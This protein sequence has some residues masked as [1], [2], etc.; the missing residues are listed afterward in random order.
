MVKIQ[1]LT[2]AGDQGP[3]VLHLFCTISI[4]LKKVLR[5]SEAQTPCCDNDAT[6]NSHNK[7]DANLQISSMS[8][9]RAALVQPSPTH[10]GAKHPGKYAALISVNDWMKLFYTNK[11]TTN[12]PIKSIMYI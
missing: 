3:E 11:I 9:K 5:K 10:S 6:T 1:K 12:I 7:K 8:R 2:E 4:I